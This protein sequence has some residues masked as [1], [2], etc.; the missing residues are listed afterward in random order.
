[1]PLNR[2]LGT[3]TRFVIGGDDSAPAGSAF[4]AAA[5]SEKNAAGPC[6]P[7]DGVR[8][9]L[10][11]GMDA[12]NSSAFAGCGAIAASEPPDSSGNWADGPTI[13]QTLGYRAA[14][15]PIENAIM[16][17]A[18]KTGSVFGIAWFLLLH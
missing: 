12:V 2:S 4:I 16:A 10:S 7:A 14:L 8:A 5:C 11:L 17:T 13:S 6:A 1:L 18:T 15:N 3:G 9:G